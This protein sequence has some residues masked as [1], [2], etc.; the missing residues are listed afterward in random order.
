[1]YGVSREMSVLQACD[2]NISSHDYTVRIKEKK[3]RSKKQC[4]TLWNQFRFKHLRNI[5]KLVFIL[6]VKPSPEEIRV[7]SQ[8]DFWALP[9]VWTY[10]MSLP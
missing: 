5:P 10:A 1:M 4:G 6:T 9:K 8:V 7:L 2:S 3:N